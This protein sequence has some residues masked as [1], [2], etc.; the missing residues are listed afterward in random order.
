VTTLV[1]IGL[2][3]ENYSVSL[4]DQA[5]AGRHYLDIHL[6]LPLLSA[7]QPAGGIH[8]ETMM[9]TITSGHL[10]HFR[11]MYLIYQKETAA[12]PLFMLLD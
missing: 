10:R 1:A 8:A 5:P 2:F 6:L 9:F 4:L 11:Y 12:L 3:F 7:R